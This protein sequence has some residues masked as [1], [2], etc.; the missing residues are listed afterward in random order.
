MRQ[1][2]MMI[3]L[4]TTLFAQAGESPPAA[5]PAR[6]NIFPQQTWQPP[7]PPPQPPPKPSAPALPFLY[8]GQLSEGE[9]IVVF[10][11]QQ[12]RQLVV[13][14]GDLIDNLYRV[15]TV[16][17]QQVVFTYLPLKQQQR[18]STGTQPR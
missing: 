4:A 5:A 8:K 13:K 10:L 11:D 14:E 15:E 6:I 18:L 3:P 7:P 9:S 16:T 2:L 12:S 1:L 17:P